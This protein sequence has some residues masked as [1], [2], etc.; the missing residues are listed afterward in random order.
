M[1]RKKKSKFN[2]LNK[3]VGLF[4]LAGVIGLLGS[5][6]T[7]DQHWLPREIHN[8]AIGQVNQ[9]IGGL[10][11]EV[12]LQSARNEVFYWMRR[13]NELKAE[14]ARN[15]RN[16]STKADLEEAVVERRRAEDNVKKLQN[17]K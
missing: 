7:L 9:S 12:A 17:A 11:K 6:W 1:V 5:V 8:I 15:P 4:G 16:I 10:Q 2:W 3:K 13:E 14:C